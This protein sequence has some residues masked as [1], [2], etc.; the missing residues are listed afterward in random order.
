MKSGGSA[1]EGL[2]QFGGVRASSLVRPPVAP[3]EGACGESVVQGGVS[4][5]GAGD[6]DGLA[7]GL[8]RPD[9]DNKGCR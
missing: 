6:P 3:R 1:V 5:A 8:G 4:A 7:D 2:V 9:E